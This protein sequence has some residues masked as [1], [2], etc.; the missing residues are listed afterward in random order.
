MITSLSDKDF[1]RL[2]TYFVIPLITKQMLDGSEPMDEVAE[3]TFHEILS[4]FRPD[5]ALLC[6]SL[7]AFHVG[8]HIETHS[9]KVLALQAAEMINEY[10]PLW[11]AHEA[12][13]P[14]LNNEDI[15]EAL[16]FIPEDIE[17]MSEMIDMTL[18][19]CEDRTTVEGILLDILSLQAGMHQDLALVELEQLNIVPSR[20]NGDMREELTAQIETLSNEL[21]G[22]ETGNII[23]FPVAAAD[24]KAKRV[25][26]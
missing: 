23:M 1:A 25:V 17:A 4:E 18:A 22:A 12:Q 9:A 24:D 6:I 13:D 26:H 5:T 14:D 15:R 16:T 7:C 21:E 19:E 8:M 20:E 2:Q 11:L 3:Y 10:G